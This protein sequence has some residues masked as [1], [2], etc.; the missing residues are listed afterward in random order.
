MRNESTNDLEK[1]IELY[2]SI[3]IPIEVSEF[4]PKDQEPNENLQA[5][6][7]IKLEALEHPKLIGYISFYTKIFFDEKGKF[8][9]QGIWE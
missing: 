3:G 7:F 1:F 4:L 9:S 6:S 8:I 2:S 5:K